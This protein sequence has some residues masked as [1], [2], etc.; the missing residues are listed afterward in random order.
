MPS[1][2]KNVG[3]EVR[4]LSSKEIEKIEV[5]ISNSANEM[6]DGAIFHLTVNAGFRISELVSLKIDD[7]FSANIVR[8]RITVGSFGKKTKSNRH[9]SLE[10]KAAKAVARHARFRLASGASPSDPL[11]CAARNPKKHL[12]TNVAW[13]ILRTNLVKAGLG[14]VSSNS[15]RHTYARKLLLRG[16]SLKNLNECLGHKSLQTS[17]AFLQRLIESSQ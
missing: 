3:G 17:G 12:T 15:L 13:D 7:V 5:T 4:A 14:H 16:V 11:F 8:E 1:R 10:R 2:P 9:I 6:R